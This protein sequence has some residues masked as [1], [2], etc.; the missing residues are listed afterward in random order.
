MSSFPVLELCSIH[1]S[2]CWAGECPTGTGRSF[3]APWKEL[4]KVES[5]AYTYWHCRMFNAARKE[6]KA[7]RLYAGL[8]PHEGLA[9]GQQFEPMASVRPR[10]GMA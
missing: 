5:I 3:G 9:R 4:A 2:L 10:P 8:R 6:S 1:V 7:L